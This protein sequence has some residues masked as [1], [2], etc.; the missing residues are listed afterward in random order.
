[1][2]AIDVAKNKDHLSI[3]IFAVNRRYCSWIFMKKKK[4]SKLTTLI[5]A[6][7]EVYVK[8]KSSGHSSE[9]VY[10]SEASSDVT[11]N[12]ESFTKRN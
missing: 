8:L 12:S 3:Y 5:D 1:M 7:I 2:E 9:E 6:V 10:W 4:I 11:L